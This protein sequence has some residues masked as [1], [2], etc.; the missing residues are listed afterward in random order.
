MTAAF[1]DLQTRNGLNSCGIPEPLH[2]T[3]AQ[4][5]C[6]VLN[7]ADL[8]IGLLSKTGSSI[9]LVGPGGW[10]SMARSRAKAT[11]LGVR[12]NCCGDRVLS[13]PPRSS[14]GSGAG[15]IADCYFDQHCRRA[16]TG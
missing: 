7:A 3:F 6:A 14:G 1:F 8:A 10:R 4:Q 13:M 11:K 2:V 5:C 9:G 15:A 12:C 16:I